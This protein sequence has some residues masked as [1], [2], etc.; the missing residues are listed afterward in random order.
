MKISPWEVATWLAIGTVVLAGLF[1][2]ALPL[3]GC[4]LLALMGGSV[5]MLGC[6]AVESKLPDS[7]R[8]EVQLPTLTGWVRSP[9]SIAIAAAICLLTSAG[10]ANLP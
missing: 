5:T 2:T 6:W 4:I 9:V 8:R 7:L 3:W 1:Q 10:F